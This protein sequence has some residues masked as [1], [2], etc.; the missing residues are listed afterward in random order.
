MKEEEDEEGEEEDQ[1]EE[2]EQEDED[3]E[4]RSH[5]NID[6]CCKGNRMGCGN[7][8]TLLRATACTVGSERA[9]PQVR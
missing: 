9:C 1:E 4:S 7:V 2:G 6:A 3:H 8:G 5:N